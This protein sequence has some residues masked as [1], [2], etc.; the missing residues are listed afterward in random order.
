MVDGSFGQAS[1]GFPGLDVV[2][3]FELEL[4]LGETVEI[5]SLEIVQEEHQGGL[6]EFPG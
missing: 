1:A 5:H 6:E 2:D 4:S 3:A